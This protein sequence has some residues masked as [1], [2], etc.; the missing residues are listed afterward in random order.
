VGDEAGHFDRVWDGDGKEE[1]TRREKGRGS[2]KGYTV[3]DNSLLP[4][5]CR[6]STY[7]HADLHLT[8][9][10]LN[11]SS[12]LPNTRPL[13]A[14]AGGNSAPSTPMV[15]SLREDRPPLG[16]DHGVIL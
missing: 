14:G 3:D 10:P 13:R 6:A 4:T 5:R 1:E 2:R 11:Y 9:T 7:L 8:S 12:L 16:M 15:P